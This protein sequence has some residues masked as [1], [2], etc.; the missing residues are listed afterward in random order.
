MSITHIAGIAVGIKSV[1]IWI[2]RCA[3]CGEVLQDIY[4]SR[5]MI[6]SEDNRGLPEFKVGSLYRVTEGNPTSFVLLGDFSEIEKLPD[7]F[8]LSLVERRP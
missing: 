4:P 2:Q 8:C 6:A 1:D 3:M 7:D 5:C